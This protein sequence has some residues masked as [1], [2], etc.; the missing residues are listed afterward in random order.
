MHIDTSPSPTARSMR[1]YE[2]QM[3]RSLRY[4]GLPNFV[5]GPLLGLMVHEALY[6]L[7]ISGNVAV[8]LPGCGVAG[9]LL[10]EMLFMKRRR[11]A[12]EAAAYEHRNHVVRSAL[13]AGVSIG[14]VK[15][16]G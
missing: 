4:L 9:W 5:V 6:L 13:K 7:G 16:H 15:I 11:I 1:S 12:R 3:L 10:V 2:Q 8:T 14:D